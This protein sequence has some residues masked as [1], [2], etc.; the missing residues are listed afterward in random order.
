MDWLKTLVPALGT[1]LA[2]PLGGAAAS[3]IAAQ[4]GLKESSVDV[5]TDM[6]AKTKLDAPQIAQLKLAEIEFQKFLDANRIKL[7][8][9]D[10]GDRKS[11]RDM[12]IAAGSWVPGA[13]AIAVTVGFFG[14]LSWMLSDPEY[15]PTDALLVMLGSLGTGWASV[16]SFYFGSSHGSRAT[17]Q[18]LV[19]RV[20]GSDKLR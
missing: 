2:G 5:V 1:A 7:E 16:I 14:I 18:A 8:E 4:L 6:L 19:E 12:Q 11:A 15:K 13:L 9:I 17:Q 10:A 20:S 3:F